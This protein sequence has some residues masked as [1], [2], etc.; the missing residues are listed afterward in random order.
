MLY[1]VLVVE[2]DRRMA[3]GLASQL[4]LLGHTVATAYGPRAAIQHLNEVIP[5]VI[6]LDL[7]M[8]GVNGVEVLRF[9]R[10]DPTTTHVPVII[11]SADDD[12][13]TKMEV[14]AAGAN[15]FIVKPPMIEDIEH[16]LKIVK[17]TG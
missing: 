9:L 15:F 17:P 4:R 14:M 8:P 13:E 3:D 16:A 10:R 11:C 2:D 6:F 1:N 5:D 12:T 7:N